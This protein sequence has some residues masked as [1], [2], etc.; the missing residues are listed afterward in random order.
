M[1]LRHWAG[2]GTVNARVISTGKNSKTIEITG[3]HEWGLD[4]PFHDEYCIENWL[5]RF[6][7]K[8]KAFSD[9]SVLANDY[10]KVNGLDTEYL[11]IT[12]FYKEA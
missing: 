5:K 10:K 3:N 7:P 1:K 2:Y 9:Y 4:R 8:G 6:Q 11:I 12:L